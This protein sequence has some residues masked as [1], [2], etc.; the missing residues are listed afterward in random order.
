MPHIIFVVD[1][2]LLYDFNIK[3]IIDKPA[4]NVQAKPSP[5][6]KFE[7]PSMDSAGLIK[8]KAWRGLWLKCTKSKKC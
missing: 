5:K 8:L 7:S 1:N 3:I 2:L 6:S 4:S